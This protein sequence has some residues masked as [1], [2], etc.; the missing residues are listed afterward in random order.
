[1]ARITE[2][3]GA[4]TVKVNVGDYQ[5]VDFFTS[6][7]AE[8]QG[9]DDPEKIAAGLQAKLTASTLAKLRA[10]FKARGKKYTDEQICRMY[11][12]AIT[13]KPKGEFG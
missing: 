3:V 12:L 7:K 10:H 6:M 4:I 5:S 13:A 9:G 11:G 8:M 2:E 1:M